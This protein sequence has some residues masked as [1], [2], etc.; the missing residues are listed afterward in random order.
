[1]FGS[2]LS[3]ERFKFFIVQFY[4][5]SKKKNELPEN[6][7]FQRYPLILVHCHFEI[8]SSHSGDCGELSHIKKSF[9]FLSEK[10]NN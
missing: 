1:M 7:L 3:Q 5:F 6:L 8:L 2:K 10:Q 9:I 4:S